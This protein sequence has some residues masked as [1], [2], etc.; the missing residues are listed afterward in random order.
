MVKIY[1]IS[2]G[3]SGLMSRLFGTIDSEETRESK[4][5]AVEQ[6]I[7]EGKSSLQ[8]VQEELKYVISP[9]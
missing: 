7:Q 5:N 4:V 9:V 3:K 8:A 1:S 6:R 2:L